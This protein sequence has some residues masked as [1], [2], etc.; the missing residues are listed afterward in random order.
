MRN[1]GGIRPPFMRTQPSRQGLK[2]GFESRHPHH[3]PELRSGVI[4]CSLRIR[5][6]EGCQSGHGHVVVGIVPRSE[7]KTERTD[8][9]R[10]GCAIKI[11]YIFPY[12]THKASTHRRSA[13]RQPPGDATSRPKTD[14]PPPC[15]TSS[16]TLT[17]DTF[18]SRGRL[19]AGRGKEGVI[20]FP[21][22]YRDLFRACIGD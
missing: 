7:F 8:A 6:N 21:S 2:S 4:L 1:K 19:R 20:I 9:N 18:P 16:V 10:I 12:T 13:Q 3:S 11:E 22:I 5:A 17:G 14:R 15:Y